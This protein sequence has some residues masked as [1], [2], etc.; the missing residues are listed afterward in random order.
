[1]LKA[2]ESCLTTIE[3]LPFLLDTVFNIKEWLSPHANELHSHT[4]PKKS[5]CKRNNIKAWFVRKKN[6]LQSSVA[7]YGS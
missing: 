7:C 3:A 1:M 5:S 4:Q 6:I 2:M